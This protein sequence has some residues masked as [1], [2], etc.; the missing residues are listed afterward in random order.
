M[1]GQPRFPSHRAVGKA[2]SAKADQAALLS[3]PYAC[4]A[5]F[6][7]EKSVWYNNPCRKAP[8]SSGP[9]YL[10]LIQKIAGSNPAGVTS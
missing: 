8:S 5:T 9:G 3:L 6:P 7:L 1:R 10:V 4:T 2:E